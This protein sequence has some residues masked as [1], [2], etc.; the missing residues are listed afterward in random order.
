VQRVADA[1]REAALQLAGHELRHDLRA[2]FHDR[3]VRQQLDRAVRRADGSHDIGTGRGWLIVHE[4]LHSLG[5]GH[6][7][8]PGSIM[9][10]TVSMTNV[11]GRAE[12]R[13]ELRA[14]PRPG[15]S[16]GDL[17]NIAA[18]YP[19]DGPSCSA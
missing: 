10:P 4:V 11:L 6:S 14:Q 19:Q 7:D 18:M 15:F 13:K 8:E 12:R 9:A 16:P 3:V 1:H 17:A 2:A 5:L